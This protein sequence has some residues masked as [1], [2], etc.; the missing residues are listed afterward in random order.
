MS[1]GDIVPESFAKDSFE[2][3]PR[4]L[5]KGFLFKPVENKKRLRQIIKDPK[6][7]KRAYLLKMFFDEDYK[8]KK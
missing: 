3:E 7:F 2:I 6:W 5:K 8:I 1:G 4:R